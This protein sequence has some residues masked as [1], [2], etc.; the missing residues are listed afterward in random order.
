MRLDLSGLV[1]VGLVG[2]VLCVGTTGVCQTAIAQ[3]DTTAVDLQRENDQLRQRIARLE[4]QLRE[5]K[6]RIKVLEAQLK[7]GSGED[8]DDKPGGGG[9][10]SDGEAGFAQTPTDP[11]ACPTSMRAALIANYDEQVFTNLPYEN[12]A[13]KVRY[14]RG[15]QQWVRKMGREFSGEV[16]WTVRLLEV[17]EDD[18]RTVTLR[19]EVLDPTSGLAYGAPTTASVAKRMVTELIGAPAKS[20]WLLSGK[21]N[22]DPQVNPDRAESDAFD[23]PAL[24]GAFVE[25]GYE[26]FVKKVR[27]TTLP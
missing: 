12:R 17:Q 2:L 4:A 27:E 6:K 13:D 22:A 3:T 5:A 7:S 25:D 16:E 10:D 18:S 26:L 20:I 8:K 19:F 23:V 24:I 9:S 21:V 14:I 15:V 1:R 11:L